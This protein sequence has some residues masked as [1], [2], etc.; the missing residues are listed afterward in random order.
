MLGV[1]GRAVE[2]FAIFSGNIGVFSE[3]FGILVWEKTV[4]LWL[5]G[6]VDELL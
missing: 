5:A 2:G 3:G 4:V 1:C 6:L